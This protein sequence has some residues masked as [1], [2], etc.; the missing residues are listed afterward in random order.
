MHFENRNRPSP[1]LSSAID[2]NAP[3]E[4]SERSAW[5]SPV[6]QK[7]D[8]QEVGTCVLSEAHKAPRPNQLPITESFQLALQPT[9]VTALPRDQVGFDLGSLDPQTPNP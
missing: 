4:T 9:V 1:V 7:L 6:G 5:A 3:F 8:W 2:L